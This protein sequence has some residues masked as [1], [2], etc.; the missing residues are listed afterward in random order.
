MFYVI[1]IGVISVGL[2][3]SAF[4]FAI[5]HDTKDPAHRRI[6]RLILFA[7]LAAMP[8]FMGWHLVQLALGGGGIQ[9]GGKYSNSYVTYQVS[10]LVFVVTAFAE[11]FASLLPLAV[12]WSSF[13]SPFRQDKDS[14]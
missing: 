11:L 7:T 3:A 4:A 10:P 14:D 2:L 5:A 8:L 9:A 6:A 13:G 12:V 1:A